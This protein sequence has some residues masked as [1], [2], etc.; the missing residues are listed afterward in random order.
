M[1]ASARSGSR[2]SCFARSTRNQNLV[3]ATQAVP[4]PDL[5]VD[6]VVAWPSKPSWY[7][8][9]TE[10]RTDRLNHRRLSPARQGE[11]CS[12]MVFIFRAAGT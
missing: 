12:A 11:S 9:A 7:I 3:W 8:V 1:F 10:D 5:F 6:G 4:V 2:S